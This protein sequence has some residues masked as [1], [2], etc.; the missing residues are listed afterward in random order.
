MIII[1]EIHLSS[2]T[3]IC[4]SV[5]PV[6]GILPSAQ[7]VLNKHLNETE[8]CFEGLI[9]GKFTYVQYHAF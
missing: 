5:S 2:G 7:Q 1:D 3:L 8:A 4:I 9:S 6:P